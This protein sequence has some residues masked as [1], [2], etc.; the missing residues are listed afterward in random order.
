MASTSLAER[1]RWIVDYRGFESA[2][3]LS[4]AAGLSQNHAGMIINGK[5][6]NP[7][8]D[9]LEKIAKTARVNYRWL[10]TGEGPVDPETPEEGAQPDEETALERAVAFAWAREVGRDPE[11]FTMADQDA[12]RAAAR[13]VANMTPPDVDIQTIGRDLLLAARQLRREGRKADPMAVQWRSSTGRYRTGKTERQQSADQ[14]FNDDAARAAEEWE[15][16]GG[17]KPPK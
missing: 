13:K 12:A 14:T 1:V 5:V 3:A 6:T 9:T 2:K 11:S 4:E 17:K 7:Q 10:V 15:R 16:N 8:R